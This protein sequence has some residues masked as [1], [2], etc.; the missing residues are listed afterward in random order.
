M[1]DISPAAHAILVATQEQFFS[2][3]DEL[4]ACRSTAAVVLYRAAWM[5]E[6]QADTLKLLAIANELDPNH[7][8]HT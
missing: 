8:L 1:S 4:S 5:C 3:Q 2:S 7:E 6:F